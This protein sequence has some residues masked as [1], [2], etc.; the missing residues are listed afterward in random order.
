MVPAGVEGVQAG[1]AVAM[2]LGKSCATRAV[3]AIA[4]LTFGIGC[5]ANPVFAYSSASSS[6]LSRRDLAHRPSTAAMP[7]SQSIRV[8]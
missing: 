3:A 6:R 7:A 1:E 8:P 4:V 2:G 5:P